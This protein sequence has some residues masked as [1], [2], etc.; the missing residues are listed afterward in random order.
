MARTI[1]A[2]TSI[3]KYYIFPKRY[4]LSSKVVLFLRCNN[5]ILEYGI[6]I[7]M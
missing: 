3:T 4:Y 6:E 1:C 5:A 7:G 2:H